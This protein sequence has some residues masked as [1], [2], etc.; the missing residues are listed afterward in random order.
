M[1]FNE[2]LLS[3]RRFHNPNLSGFML[4]HFGG[5]DEH[6]TDLG[7]L[8]EAI[9]GDERDIPDF[10]KMATEQRTE[11]ERSQPSSASSS[12]PRNI[13]F[14]PASTARVPSKSNAPLS[15]AQLLQE[16]RDQ[17]QDQQQRHNKDYR[18]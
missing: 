15:Y 13:P 18:R 9:V 11:W 14:V 5:L 12:Q 2:T 7:R 1:T 3:K 6:G 4:G 17:Q 8:L 16:R 10:E